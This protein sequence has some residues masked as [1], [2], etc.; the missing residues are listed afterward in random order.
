[1]S[2]SGMNRRQ[3]LQTSSLAAAG[4]AVVASGT[5]L[6]SSDGAWALDL[7]SLSAHEG[8]TLLKM[9]RRLYPHDTLSDIYYAAV[10]GALDSEAKGNADTAALIKDGV[11]KLDA[12]KGVKWV[13]LSDGYQL[14]VLTAMQDDA[15]FQ[16]VRG[17][18]VVSL[19]NDRL[20]WRHF[21]YEGPSYE[22]GGYLDRGFDDLNWLERPSE[23]A[24][25]KAG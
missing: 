9:S 3:F 14:E 17:T 13:E 5:V 15:F 4:A 1:M 20:V 19:Y 25:P 10:V 18:T 8:M 2:K 7:Q 23:D 11:G 12:A 24:S 21:G 16:K 6:M 22:F